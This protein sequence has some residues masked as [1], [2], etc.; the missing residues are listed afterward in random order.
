[1]DGIVLLDKPKGMRSREC[2]DE[3]KH[4]FN[5]SHAGHS[6]TL[7]TNAT[8]LL[9][10]ALGEA[11]KAMPVFIGLEKEYSGTIH[12]HGNAEEEKIKAVLKGFEGEVEQLPPKRS[13][14]RRRLRRR[15]I[16]FIGIE[17]IYGRDVNFRI[18]CGAGLYIRKLASD[19]GEKLDVGA[20]LASLR[21]TAVGN[22]R[23]DECAGFDMLKKNP[24]RHLI[25]LEKAMERAGLKKIFLREEAVEKIRKGAPLLR[26]WAA[27][28]DEGIEKNQYVGLYF[29]D[30]IVALGVSKI[31]SRRVGGVKVVAKTERVFNFG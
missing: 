2:V 3:V 22:F 9:L 11:R 7:D 23:I 30:R 13:A 20:H 28:M 8:G 14:V 29:E 18:R 19:F 31:D 25:P 6:G 10:I 5:T 17:R 26:G 27:G 4:I 24:Y 15:S 21:R 1:M 16:H 12:L